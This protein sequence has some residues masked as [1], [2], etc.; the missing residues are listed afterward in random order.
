ME[1][2][3]LSACLH[4]LGGSPEDLDFLCSLVPK[5]MGPLLADASVSCSFSHV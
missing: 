5:L 1:T 3:L 2:S 4:A